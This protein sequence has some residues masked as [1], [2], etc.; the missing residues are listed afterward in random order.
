MSKESKWEDAPKPFEVFGITTDY[1]TWLSAYVDKQSTE[2]SEL[3]ENCIKFAKGQQA[4]MLSPTAIFGNVVYASK[5]RRSNTL[6]GVVI[7]GPL[8]RVN[9]EEVDDKSAEKTVFTKYI[10]PETF[11]LKEGLWYP[12]KK[13]YRLRYGVIEQK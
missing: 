3:D 5:S 9:V 2:N 11:E 7:D 12:K 4:Y 13:Q 6:E 1:V 8:Y 10:D